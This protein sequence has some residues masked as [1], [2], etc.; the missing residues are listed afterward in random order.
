MKVKKAEK[1]TAKL[2]DIIDKNGLDY[3]TDEP[4]E[5]YKILV[6]KENVDQKAASMILYAL[7]NEVQSVVDS[8]SDMESAAKMIQNQCSLSKKGADYLTEIFL[9]LYSKENEES[10]K[11]KELEGFTQFLEED[12]ECDWRGFSVWE[13]ENGT[14][15][16]SYNADIVLRPTGKV[17][18]DKELSKLLKKNPFTTKEAIQEYFEKKL[19]RYLA[20]NFEE[21]CTE[22][23]YYQPV[24]EDFELEEYVSEWA[25]K[26]GF[27]V[28]LCE[29][30]GSDGG[31]E[32]KSRGWY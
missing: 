28:I 6:Q 4:Y 24:V 30:E 18:Q 16:C 32:P 31:F 1:I 11:K 13:V 19:C 22:D 25:G 5:V 17:K 26:N 20:D 27:E 15:D 8:N 21:Y 23:D 10:W 29:G 9:S 12:F 14:V 7:V 2:K 3:L